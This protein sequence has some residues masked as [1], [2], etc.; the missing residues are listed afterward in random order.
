MI[1]ISMLD[2]P[3]KEV[4]KETFEKRLPIELKLYYNKSTHNFDHLQMIIQ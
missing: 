3:G 1:N 4:V 2:I